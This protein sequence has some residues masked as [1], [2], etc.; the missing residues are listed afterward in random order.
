MHENNISCTMGKG[1][2][3]HIESLPESLMADD[4]G[5]KGQIFLKPK[6]FDDIFFK[7]SDSISKTTNDF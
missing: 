5:K 6:I 7:Y 1:N 4:L 2:C 3:E